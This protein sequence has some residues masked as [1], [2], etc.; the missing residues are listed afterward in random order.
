M[1][2]TVTAGGTV[3]FAGG[4]TAVALDSGLTVADV[5]SG[6]SLV[7]ATVI[8]GGFVSGDTL[9]VATPGTLGTSFSNGTLTLTGTASLSTYQTALDSVKFGFTSG[10]D[11]TGGGTHTSR[12]ISWSINDGVVLS[13]TGHGRKECPDI[14]GP[15]RRRTTGRQGFRPGLHLHRRAAHGL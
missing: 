3:A 2:P 15:E 5:D 6:G 4:G 11:P 7:S 9:T 13:N 8:E 12:T 10:G 1:A 14:P